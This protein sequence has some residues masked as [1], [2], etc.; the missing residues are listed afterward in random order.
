MV[1]YDDTSLSLH[2]QRG[3]LTVKC[4]AAADAIIEVA[5][6]MAWIGSSLREASSKDEVF[7]VTPCLSQATNDPK[8]I[9]HTSRSSTIRL[10]INFQEESIPDLE[11]GAES[12][13][14]WRGL[15]GNPVIA[16][17]FPVL[18]RGPDVAGLEVSLPVMALLLDAER[19]TTQRTT[20]FLKGFNAAAVPTAIANDIVHWHLV[21]N[22][23]G[24]RLSY[25]N[26]RLAIDDKTFSMLNEHVIRK[27][28]HVLGWTLDAVHN[29]GTYIV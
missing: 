11:A 22:K 23:T 1:L 20:I 27:S 9:E 10:A 12:G 15:L 29:V 16:K 6:I 7:Y 2:L 13:F 26:A 8:A 14:C 28:R 17:G 24:D 25:N 21:T 3:L 5:E 19:L 18:L 4:K